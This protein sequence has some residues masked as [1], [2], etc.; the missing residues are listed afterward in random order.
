MRRRAQFWLSRVSFSDD[1]R[2]GRET[3][4]QTQEEHF[5]KEEEDIVLVSRDCEPL[6]PSREGVSK[7]MRE[8]RGK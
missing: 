3:E 6:A 4:N 8:M 1:I 5:L 7:W 2:H